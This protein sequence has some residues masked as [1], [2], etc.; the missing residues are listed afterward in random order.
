MSSE[1]I[2]DDNSF[3]YHLTDL[4]MCDL[5]FKKSWILKSEKNMSLWLRSN[6]IFQ[7]NNVLSVST[8][9]FIASGLEVFPPSAVSLLSVVN[10][11]VQVTVVFCKVEMSACGFEACA[12]GQSDSSNET[13]LLALMEKTGYSM[14]QEN[15]Q[16]KFGGPPPGKKWN[17]MK[18]KTKL[19]NLNVKN[20]KIFLGLLKIISKVY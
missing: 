14:I 7:D 8:E 3:T 1:Q 4:F 16:R 19:M 11:S 9:N 13:A 12:D 20:K 15:G 6:R 10:V 18:N 2:L 17:E 5:Q